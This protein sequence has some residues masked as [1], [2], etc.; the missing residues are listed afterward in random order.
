MRIRGNSVARQ[1]AFALV[2]LALA[3]RVLIPSGW[4]PVS[5]GA[6]IAVTLCTADGPIKLRLPDKSSLHKAHDP[7]PFGALATA[8]LLPEQAPPLVLPYSLAAVPLH[9]PAA[10]RPHVGVPAPPP[11]STGPPTHLA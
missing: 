10:V 6:G 9:R 4:M 2:A 3:L 7:C 11:P 1:W 5:G 8:P